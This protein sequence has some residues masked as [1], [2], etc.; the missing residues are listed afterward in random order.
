MHRAV[1]Q[2]GR[3][4]SEWCFVIMR[5]LIPIMPTARFAP[6]TLRATFGIDELVDAVRGKAVE[7][8]L[9]V[10]TLREIGLRGVERATE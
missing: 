7:Q 4:L 10:G 8:R 2:L 5:L 3:R 1:A 9:A 6:V